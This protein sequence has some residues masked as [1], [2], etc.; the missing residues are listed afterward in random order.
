M[1]KRTVVM[2]YHSPRAS[3]PHEPN[4]PGIIPHGADDRMDDRVL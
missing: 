4:N 3:L 2:A 1:E